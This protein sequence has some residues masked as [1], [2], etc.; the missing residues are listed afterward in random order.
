MVFKK[1]YALSQLLFNF[2]YAFRKVKETQVGLKLNGKHQL[3]VHAE[4]MNLRIA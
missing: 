2:F 4:D 1:G 3:L